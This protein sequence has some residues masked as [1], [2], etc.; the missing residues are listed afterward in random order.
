MLALPVAAAI[1]VAALGA[2][3][4]AAQAAPVL[5]L[6]HNGRV[7]LRNDP[8]LAATSLT[9]VPSAHGAASRQPRKMPISAAGAAV[10]RQLAS[11]YRRHSI[12]RPADAYYAAALGSALA[13]ERRL[14]GTRA[15][16]LGGVISNLGQ[17]A[18]SG[19]LAPSRLPALFETLGRNRQWWTTGSLLSYGQR[20]EFAG[21]QIVWEYYPGQG[22]ELQVL[23]TFGKAD[24]LYAAGPADY[25]QLQTLLADMIP[26]AAWR[27]DSLTWEYYFSFD[28]GSPP[29]TSAMSQGTALDALALGY[30]AFHNLSY[31][32]IANRALPIFTDGPPVGVS[33]RTRLGRR[34]L[35][36][37]FDPGQ[38]VING[39]LQTLIG[40][41]TY[42]Q[43]SGNREAAQLFAA[44]NAEAQ[45]E[46]PGYDTGAWSLYV[47]GQED[48][49]SYHVLVT[50]FL[51]QLCSFVHAAVYCAT[52]THFQAYL[53]T[54][55]ALQLLTQGVRARHPGR[56]VFRLSKYSHVGIVVTRN[57]AVVFETSAEFPYGVD[58]FS[59]P[60]PAS[61]GQYQVRLAA[62]DLAG[63][64]ARIEGP[65]QVS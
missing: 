5:V 16:E 48:T 24:G 52:A 43:V 47:P 41:Y 50:G 63:N 38:A 51:Q 61:G 31:L 34:Y 22:I 10:R 23:G 11:L 1:V 19:Q 42:A 37:S 4:T 49:L 44:G 9:P 35:L 53:K 45:A 13:A 2:F 25:P 21:S 18:G 33:V 7:L 32:G 58:D 54:P 20:V 30:E 64:F 27:A 62:T 46:L 55:P 39:F 6:G 15:A 8:F 14:G 12:T 40:L 17:I 59:I 28:G 65:L 29:W 26:L 36:Y 57:G 60:A 3:S 56:I